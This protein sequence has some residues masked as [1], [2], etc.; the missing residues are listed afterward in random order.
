MKL[1]FALGA[2]VSF[3]GVPENVGATEVGVP[4]REPI[5]DKRETYNSSSPRFIGSTAKILYEYEGTTK[6]CSANLV[7]TSPE[8]PSFIVVGS[9]HCAEELLEAESHSVQFPNPYSSFHIEK[10]LYWEAKNADYS[11]MKLNKK[12]SVN[13]VT[14][15]V[16]RERANLKRLRKRKDTKYF[17]V[18]FDSRQNLKFHRN[19]REL[20]RDIVTRLT[21]CQGSPGNSGGSAVVVRNNT[22]YIVGTIKGSEDGNKEMHL[23]IT[24]VEYYENE[25]S[26]AL[27]MYN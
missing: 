10:I 15:L 23:K 27:D 16:Y 6:I 7:S 21:N 12:P 1:L 14:P 18:G 3:A 26:S 11:I 8:I 13:A 4:T 24:T 5:N 9:G 19:C 25:L 20:D 22:N 17:T 2:L